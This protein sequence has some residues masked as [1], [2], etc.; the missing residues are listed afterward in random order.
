MD[1]SKEE[2]E[3]LEEI[4]PHWRAQQWLQVAT[5]GIRDEEVLWHELL[6]LLTSG[7]EGAAKALAKHLV[8]MWW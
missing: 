1:I 4:N 7:A 3:T 2:L 8:A 5:Q 6:A